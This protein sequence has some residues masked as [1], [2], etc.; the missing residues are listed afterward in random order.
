M[1]VEVP[2]LEPNFDPTARGSPIAGKLKGSID[3]AMGGV[4]VAQ[5]K[6]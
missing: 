4:S 2:E 5:E 3:G 6:K 1:S